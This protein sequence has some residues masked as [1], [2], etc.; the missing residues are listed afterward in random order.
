MITWVAL[1]LACTGVNVAQ[2]QS[3]VYPESFHE[4]NDCQTVLLDKMEQLK[5]QGILALG[6][7][8]RIKVDLTLL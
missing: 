4:A 1:I 2:C 7:C 3:L 6:S 5:Q 8:K